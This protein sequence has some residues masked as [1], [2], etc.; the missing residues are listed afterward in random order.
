VQDKVFT[1][2]G[3]QKDREAK[4][5]PDQE[6]ANFSPQAVLKPPVS[7]ATQGVFRSDCL[8]EWGSKAYPIREEENEKSQSEQPSPLVC[9]LTALHAIQRKTISSRYT[10]FMQ[11][12]K[13]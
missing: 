4:N 7:L 10:E 5:S 12:Y 9:D 2:Q 6:I 8:K 1:K 11:K 13:K 3:E